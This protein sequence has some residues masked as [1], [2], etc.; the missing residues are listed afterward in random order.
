[1]GSLAVIFGLYVVLWG[2]AKD[3]K[4]DNILEEEPV[5]QHIQ[6]TTIAIQDFPDFTSF[7]V[8]LEEPLL[9]NKSITN[10]VDDH[11]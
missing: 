4:E 10:I 6:E 2:K 8:D 7:K 1:M 3:K 9:T 5:K 11:I